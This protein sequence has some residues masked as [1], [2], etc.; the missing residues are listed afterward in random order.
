MA[1]L[2]R[3]VNSWDHDGKLYPG[4]R[5]KP[6]VLAASKSV[7]LPADEK[8][9]QIEFDGPEKEEGKPEDQ[10]TIP[11]KAD[12]IRKSEEPSSGPEVTDGMACVISDNNDP[13][14]KW[15][16][17]IELKPLVPS[18]YLQATSEYKRDAGRI[19]VHVEPR[20]DD[21]D[22]TPD[23]GR[24]LPQGL[25]GESSINVIW[26]RGGAL[27]AKANGAFFGQIDSVRSSVD[28]WASVPARDAT[29]SI[30]LSVD[31]YPRAFVHTLLVN[32]DNPGVDVRA[33]RFIRINS[34]SMGNLVYLTSPDVPS[35]ELQEGQRLVY[36][37]NSDAA[38]FPASSDGALL[39]VQFQ[40]DAP[41]DA[42]SQDKQEDY[43]QVG[44]L[45]ANGTRFYS[46][47]HVRIQFVAADPGGT[48]TL[49]TQVT[50]YSHRLET[51]GKQ[52]RFVIV[53]GGRV[54]GDSYLPHEV[55]VVLDG[56]PP[57]P[58]SFRARRTRVRQGEPIQ[59]VVEV[60]DLSGLAQ[61]RFGLTKGEADEIPEDAELHAATGNALSVSIK[62]DELAPGDYWIQ[63]QLVDRVG[64]QLNTGDLG[65]APQSVEIVA[66]P[67]STPQDGK[68]DPKPATG[69]LRGYVEFGSLGFK[70]NGITVKIKGTNRQTTTQDGGRFQFANVPT[71]EQAY[72][73][74]A[75]GFVSGL[76]KTGEAEVQLKTEKDFKSDAVI[77]I[78]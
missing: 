32:R 11:D 73:L 41:I 72:V 62:T 29:V 38:A 54:R 55:Q 14:E 13:D 51:Q 19:S 78:K 71:Q 44:W 70:P 59:V 21:G 31:R 23:P 58:L 57:R 61:A 27:L 63:S 39:N 66:R 3:R 48:V 1:R 34:L 60:E 64:H 76:P 20:D 28:L 50:D 56:Q 42:F 17:W 36:L 33:D 24:V 45:N 9:R 77:S 35:P 25:E 37:Q 52:G 65:F 69:T 12:G 5:L 68:Q 47:R 15:V 16:K 8:P 10:T 4:I 2:S 75:R 53:A 49:A 40:V 74:E 6:R 22:G 67:K 46:D 7:I 30:P 18:E 26:E 43:V